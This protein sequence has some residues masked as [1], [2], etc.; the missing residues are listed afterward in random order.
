MLSNSHAPS[1]AGL[2]QQEN[3]RAK[4]FDFGGLSGHTLE[5]VAYSRGYQDGYKSGKREKR[6]P[7]SVTEAF[8]RGLAYGY[9]KAKGEHNRTLRRV[10]DHMTKM[11]WKLRGELKA[12]PRKGA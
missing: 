9:S 10:V 7:I 2:I 3:G 6:P 11:L 4:G 8:Q 5:Q 1:L 12:K